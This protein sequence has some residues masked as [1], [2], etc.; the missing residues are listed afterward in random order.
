MFLLPFFKLFQVCFCSSFSSVVFPI[1]R[2]SFS[3]CCKVGLVVLNSLSFY[4]SVKLLTSPS[5]L[6]NIFPGQ[7]NLGCTFKIFSCSLLFIL[8][9]L[10]LSC[11]ISQFLDFRKGDSLLH[12]VS[13]FL[14]LKLSSSK[15]FFFNILKIIYRNKF[16]LSFV[17]PH[18]SIDKRNRVVY[19]LYS[20][21]CFHFQQIFQR[22]FHKMRSSS[23]PFLLYSTV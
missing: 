1:Q 10:P 17:S 20:E 9:K 15:I 3:N 14:S 6:N 16:S 13:T 12:D 7:S 11:S 5:N 8:Q 22:L 23:F 4:L 19:T 21:T 2:S 18:Y